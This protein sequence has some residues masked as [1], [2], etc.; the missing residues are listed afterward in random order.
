MA[1]RVVEH[2]FT[3]DTV[4]YA[5]YDSTKTM[6]GTL[7]QQRTGVDP[8]DKFA[9]PMPL[10]LARPME[11]STAIAVAYPHVI[12]WD[13]NTE[14]IF[15]AENSTAAATRRIVMYTYN[16]ATTSFSWTGFITLTLPTVTL[17]TVRGFRM[18]RELYI[19][20]TASAS[21]TAVTGTGTAW[22]A[23]RLSAGCRIGFG[24]TDPTQ[25]STWYEISAIGSDTG[26]TLT[27]TAGT[28]GDGAYVIE[29]L[30]VALTTT[31]A[32][33]A[34]GGL[35]L[36]KGLRFENFTVAG[37]IIAS[38]TTA[39]NARLCYWLADAATVLNTIGC[40]LALGDRTS[41]TSQ[42]VYVID[43]TTTTNRVYKYNIRAAL[44]GLA[45]G[46]STSAIDLVTG[47]QTP[48]GTVSQNNNGR[49]GSLGHGP[50]S[51]V[52]SL[53]FVTTTRVYRAALANITA[54]N[55]A[56][57]S[58][59]MAEIP[60]GGTATHAINSVLSSVEISSTI[61]KLIVMSTGA[62]G[63]RSYV[64]AYSTNPVPFDHIF[65]S[66]TKQQDQ[67]SVDNDT[68]P[69]PSILAVP[70]SVWSEGGIAYLC[71][72][73]TT[74]A[75]NH[76]YSMPV[77]AH[78]TYASGTPNQRL[79]TPSIAT[80]N[81]SSLHRVYFSF[82]RQFLDVDLS[83][84]P[85]SFRAFYRTTGISDNSGSWTAV[86]LVGDLSAVTAGS[87]IQFMF[88]FR[89]FG[90]TGIPSRIF[91]LAVVY[92]DFATDSHYQPSVGESDLT[93]SIFAWR[94][95]TAF[96]GTV[97]T[98]RVRLYDAVAGNLLVDDETATPTG[99]F[100]KSTN[101]GASWAAYDTV[102]KTNETTYIRYTPSSLGSGIKVR[103]LLTQN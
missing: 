103:A 97:P 40:G 26:I 102:D 17:H 7:I 14:Y 82:I 48:T 44:A 63:S 92:E 10:G 25:I 59:A 96:G 18:V 4:A 11:A 29:D 51:G 93:S 45:A 65:L 5:A 43:G 79:I 34:N 68:E 55:V 38:A 23:S 88:E 64:T 22:L 47:A 89:I 98:L 57:H 77:A 76:M 28:I 15:L 37:T 74:A 71:R 36:V 41:W 85:E 91:G 56:W 13:S 86:N 67:T 19:T 73:G 58:D 35:F 52:D 72:N 87:E 12:T 84:Q 30:M 78:W 99:T 62:S 94:F 54:A 90:L 8:E 53:Y 16:K 80:P 66:D 31:N 27:A 33:A 95:S 81:A 49:V 69:H 60:P 24:S 2:N 9:G 46:K 70:Y 21:G 101:D 20:G 50:G 6:L 32:T 39:D 83:V 1:Q 61:D 100:E 42:F 3:G 75:N